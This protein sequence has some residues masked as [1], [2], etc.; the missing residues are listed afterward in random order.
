M[1]REWVMLFYNI[2]Q[3][4]IL[5]GLWH[6]QLF[7]LLPLSFITFTYLSV[8][9]G[10]SY[11]YLF[12][13]LFGCTGSQLGHA[14]SFTATRWLGSCRARAYSLCNSWDLSSSTRD[15]T[16]VPCIGRWI[17]SH[18]TTREIPV[19]F[20]VGGLSFLV[21]IPLMHS[22]WLGLKDLRGRA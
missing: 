18:W 1:S 2:E 9:F 19:S 3:L 22:P 13:Y 17:L 16:Y 4:W 7:N 20:L 21:G 15:W 11:L 5:P 12:I 14:G 6:W 10:C 8:L